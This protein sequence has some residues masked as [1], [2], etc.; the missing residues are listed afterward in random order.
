MSFIYATKYTSDERHR[1]C[2]RIFSDTQVK[3]KDATTFNWGKRPLEWVQR[4]GLVKSMILTPKCCFSFAGNN[5]RF[6]NVFLERLYAKRF[7]SDDE[8]ISLAFSVHQEAGQENIEFLFCI[9]DESDHISITC[10]KDGRIDYDCHSAWLGSY[11]T[12]RELQKLH[13]EQGQEISWQIIRQAI[14]NCQKK[15]DKEDGRFG[16]GGFIVEVI[17]D[18]H[19]HQFLYTERMETWFE[20][21]QLVKLGDT[22]KLFATAEEGGYTAHYRESSRDFVVDLDQP[23]ITVGFTSQYRLA[24]ENSINSSTNHLMLPILM[25][26]E[27]VGGSYLRDETRKLET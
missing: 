1:K 25:Q 19:L 18:F 24:E 27:T 10:V 14:S 22:I 16:V 6:A 3:P 15:P 17:Y 12:F 13:L 5:I 23:K 7:C 21:K 8:L 20:R 11:D 26:T 4:Y 9:A 2:V